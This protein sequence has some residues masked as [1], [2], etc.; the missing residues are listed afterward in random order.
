MH[1]QIMV[2]QRRINPSFRSQALGPRIVWGR[3]Q[4]RCNFRKDEQQAVAAER[5]SSAPPP[6]KTA[7]KKLPKVCL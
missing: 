2:F 6:T 4:L 7:L 3:K 1:V 5:S